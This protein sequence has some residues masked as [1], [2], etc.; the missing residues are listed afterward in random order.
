MFMVMPRMS[1]NCG[2]QVLGHRREDG[3]VVAAFL[4]IPDLDLGE[5]FAV[6]VAG[7][8]HELLGLLRDRT[9]PA[10]TIVCV[11]PRIAGRQDRAGRDRDVLE[12]GR[13][14]LVAVDR[15]VE[16]A[17]HVDI[18]ERRGFEVERDVGR[19]EHRVGADRVREALLHHRDLAGVEVGDSRRRRRG[20][21]ACRLPAA[22][23]VGSIVSS[24]TSAG[25]GP[26]YS[27]GS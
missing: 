18:V 2:L 21:P 8:G 24:S 10:A 16:G 7:L 27:R 23:I 15:V 25:H 1:L 5:A 22:P 4:A 14:Q 6:R 17:A 9:R 19:R 20:R 3:A 26:V 11:V 13:G 12:H